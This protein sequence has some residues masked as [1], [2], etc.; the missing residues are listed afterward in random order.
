MSGGGVYAGI[1]P[2]TNKPM[3]TTPAD[4]PLAYAFNRAQKHAARLAAHGQ[5]DWRVPSKSELN[6]LFQGRTA[7]GWVR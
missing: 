4:A 7:I 3:S 2:D 1:S 6:V 5:Q